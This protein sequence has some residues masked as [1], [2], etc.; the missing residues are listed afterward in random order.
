MNAGREHPQDKGGPQTYLQSP[1]PEQASFLKMLHASPPAPRP[2]WAAA[3]VKDR[4]SST[5]EGS[6]KEGSSDEA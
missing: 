4:T 1:S 6:S 2:P 5:R 3:A